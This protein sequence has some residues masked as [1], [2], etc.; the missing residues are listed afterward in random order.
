MDERNQI[1]S[2][3]QHQNNQKLKYINKSIW[4]KK[5]ELQFKKLLKS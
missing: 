4:N 2:K 5:M 1:Q 3:I